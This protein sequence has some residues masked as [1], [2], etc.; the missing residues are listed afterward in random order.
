[1]LGCWPVSYVYLSLLVPLSQC[2]LYSFSWPLPSFFHYLGQQ[3]RITR[4]YCKRFPLY[5]L[6][7]CLSLTRWHFLY[8]SFLFFSQSIAP[9][10]LISPSLHPFPFIVCFS[11]L[12]FR[13]RSLPVLISCYFP[14][15]SCTA[16]LSHS[17]FLALH[18]SLSKIGMLNFAL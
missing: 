16:S 4:N 17:S 13:M 14:Q 7:I 3:W 9:C 5:V 8:P 15:S 6:S 1:M 2:V 12:R 10:I 18:P 11:P